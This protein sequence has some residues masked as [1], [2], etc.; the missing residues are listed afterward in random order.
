MFDVCKERPANNTHR[1]GAV[2]IPDCDHGSHG[3][4]EGATAVEAEPSKPDESRSQKDD[5]DVVGLV[6]MFLCQSRSLAK[7]K[8]IGECSCSGRD[9][10]GPATSKV[11]STEDVEPAVGVPGPVGDGAVADSAPAEAEDDG[12]EDTASFEG[13][14]DHDHGG[15]AGEHEFVE[16]EDDV[17]EDGATPRR[18]GHDLYFN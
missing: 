8:S 18:C 7:N 6:V 17:R 13:A 1:G 4:I 9:M 14:S 2:G 3:G 11:Q 12:G 16:A 5:S 15:T 10:H